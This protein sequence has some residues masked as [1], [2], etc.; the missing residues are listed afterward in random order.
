MVANSVDSSD[1]QDPTVSAEPLWLPPGVKFESL[2]ASL[3]EAVV[4]VINPA[5]QAYVQD[6]S[7]ALERGEGLSYCTLL[8][9]E[10]WATCGLVDRAA[11]VGVSRLPGSKA[12]ASL[13][14]VT[15]Q[16][17]KVASFL[18]RLH[19]FRARDRAAS[20]ATPAVQP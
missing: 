9:V 13:M 6:A 4:A 19:K 11:E 16:K 3:Q 17:T 12:L 7:N 10:L 18:L 20:P 1:R 14:A 15:G 5:F 2:P 8:F